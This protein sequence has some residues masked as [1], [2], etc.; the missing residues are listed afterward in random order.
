MF[1][2]K[3]IFISG[4]T[5]SFGKKF[6]N[7]ILN[8]HNPKKIILL[9]RDEVKQFD[10]QTSLSKYLSKIKFVIGD[11]RDKERLIEAMQGADYV[12]NAAALKQVPTAENNP[13]E[14]IKTNINGTQNIIDAAIACKVK[15]AITLSTDKA[16]NPINLYGATKLVAD[17]LFISANNLSSNKNTIFSVTRYGNVVGSRGSIVPFFKECIRNENLFFPITDHRMTRFWITLD[18]SCD[19][20]IKNFSRMKGGEI[21]IP[22]IPSIYITDLAKAMDPNKKQK[23]IGIRS[24]EK[25]GEIMFSLEDSRLAIEFKDHF[26]IHPFINKSNKSNPYLKNNMREVGIK[27][28]KDFEYSSSTNKHFLNLR[29][30]KSLNE[31]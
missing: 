27:I 31:K 18:Q 17:K 16:A 3:V 22:K 9:S 28:K 13:S 25:L 21:F 5:G 8:K 6:I 26:V 19:F 24:G 20:V 7:T 14:F 12:L 1:K 4:G 11:I 29:Q 30:I 2:D 15:K 23:I 10:M